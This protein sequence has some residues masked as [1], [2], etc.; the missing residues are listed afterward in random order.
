MQCPR[1]QDALIPRP[2]GYLPKHCAAVT[3]AVT[4]GGMLLFSPEKL[5]GWIAMA[6]LMLTGGPLLH[7]LCLLAEELIYH[8]NTR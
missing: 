1:E 2:R 8:S 7:G 3:A 6:V 4:I 5:L